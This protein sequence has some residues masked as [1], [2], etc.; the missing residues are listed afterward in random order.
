MRIKSAFL[1]CGV[2]LLSAV[3]VLADRIPYPAPA[4]KS[5]D[6]TAINGGQDSVVAVALI[7]NSEAM[8]VNSWVSK[9]YVGLQS[10]S[11][12]MPAVQQ[13]SSP[14]FGSFE[15]AASNANVSDALWARREG[16][17]H[18]ILDPARHHD[19][20]PHSHAELVPEPGS[21]PLVL[22]GLMAI[23]LVS[24]RRSRLA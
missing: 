4:G 5:L 22:V 3:P 20:N 2:V 12:Y 1:L 21:L 14:E 10:I 13:I 16:Y 9:P 11:T 8:T 17:G 24:P 18:G 19:N 15:I 23:G 7:D 6:K